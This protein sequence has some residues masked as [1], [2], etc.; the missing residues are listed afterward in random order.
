VES[1]SDT[2][3]IIFEQSNKEVVDLIRKSDIVIGKGQANFYS[4]YDNADKIRGTAI[5]LMFTKCSI[6][7]RIFGYEKKIGVACIVKE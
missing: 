6:V 7:S 4:I 1:G 2:L 3:G 5:S